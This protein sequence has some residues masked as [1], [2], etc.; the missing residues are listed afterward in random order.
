MRLNAFLDVCHQQLIRW[1]TAGWVVTCLMSIERRASNTKPLANRTSGRRWRRLAHSSNVCCGEGWPLTASLR[2]SESLTNLLTFCFR[3]LISRSCCALSSK[4]R[5]R[6]AFSAP[7]RKRSRQSSISATVN[8]Y[9]RAASTTDVSPRRISMT[10][11]DRNVYRGERWGA[12]HLWRADGQHAGVL[13]CK[14]LQASGAAK[15]NV[16]AA[17]RRDVSH[18]RCAH[19]WCGGLL[20]LQCQWTGDV[21]NRHVLI[22]RSLSCPGG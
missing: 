2:M 3:R 13:G 19:G 4:G 12:A 20:G 17:Q 21:A 9:F 5:L 15:W 22:H 1:S 7:D 18:L 8:P 14:W 6:N 11:A 16:S 10:S